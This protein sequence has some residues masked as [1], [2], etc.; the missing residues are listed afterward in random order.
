MTTAGISYAGPLWHVVRCAPRAE[1]KVADGVRDELG[2]PVCLPI[3]R[4]WTVLRGRKV[5]AARPVFQGY[6][7]VQVDPYRQEWQRLLEIDGVVDVLGRSDTDG[8]DR[9]PAH[10]PRAWIEAIQTAEAAGAF[11]HVNATN[12]FNVGDTVRVLEGPFAGLSGEI[13]HFIAKLRCN[14]PERRAK[15]LVAMMG[16]MTAVEADLAN[17]ERV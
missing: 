16:R 6:G 7:F 11:D 14:G 17:V 12:G 13:A 8:R 1:V 4:R 9:V 5:E 10:V 2:Y 15:L 3:E